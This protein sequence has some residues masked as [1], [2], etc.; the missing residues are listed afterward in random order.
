MPPKG[1]G[2]GSSANRGEEP[3]SNSSSA[4]E[5]ASLTRS[6]VKGV[7]WIT[8]GR[9]VRAPFNLFAVAV[10]ARLL[11]PTDFGVVALGFIVV[12]FTN[13]MVDG[14][15]G[16]VLIQ[17][18]SINP[19]LIG[20]SLVA[21][22]SLAGLFGAAIIIAAPF[23][24]REFDFPQLKEVLIVL[25]A[26]VPVIGITTVT[27]SL[28]QRSLKYGVLTVNGLITQSVYVP[29]AIGLAFAGFGLWSLIWAQAV[30][31]VLDALLGYLTVRKHYRI[32]FS[33]AALRD[34]LGSGGMFTVSKLLGWAANS[35]DRIVIGRYVGAAQL[36]LYSRASTLMTTVMQVS[37]AGPIKVLFA[38]LSKIQH[39]R[40]RMA[41]AYFRALAVAS[42]AA[43]LVSALVIVNAEAI[44]RILLGPR[45]LAAVPLM[46]ILFSAF[47]ARSGYA[48]AEAVPLALGLSG[49]SAVRQ[50]AQLALVLA[51]AAVGARFGVVGAAIGI[52]IAYWLFY[53]ICLVLAQRLLQA[54]WGEILR[55][56]LNGIVVAAPPT[57][58]ALA[59]SWLV[60]NE[61]LLAMCVPIVVFAAV[62]AAVLAFAPA[63]LV[64][65][66]VALARAH[67]WDKLSPHLPGLARPR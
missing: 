31:Y 66:D 4:E 58:L 1:K 2:R 18:R 23:I 52:A 50:G 59:A 54:D 12:T 28:L 15:F 64:S 5:Q 45:W 65:D 62:A 26:V 27:G 6:T 49:Q 21:C 32:G 13:V 47:V 17:K 8:T 51:G 37:G 48:I 16:M 33:T 40:A 10:L 43:T 36:G 55:L 39:D 9:L 46:Q 19:S 20:A 41:R 22:V 67:V 3:N 56:H 34:V 53:F 30:Q 42:I 14:S 63:S 7:V 44:V 11:T 25:G 57:L 29:L 24:Q 35:V 38:S 60:G 61:T